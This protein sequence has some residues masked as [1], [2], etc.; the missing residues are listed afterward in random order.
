MPVRTPS[1]LSSLALSPHWLSARR[2]AAALLAAG[3]LVLAVAPAAQPPIVNS[4]PPQSTVLVA[5]QDLPAGRTIGTDDLR[6]AE[7]TSAQLPD[8]ALTPGMDVVGRVVTGSVRRGEVMTDRRLLGPGLSA[9]LDAGVVAS[10]V[11]LVDLEVSA[12]LRPGDRVDI[13][14]AVQDA[15]SATVVAAG[16]VVLAVP[17][18]ES[19]DSRPAEPIGLVVVAVDQDTAARLAAAAAS[20]RLTATLLP[21]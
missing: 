19:E 18:A 3:A 5:A 1:A 14:A 16:V 2:L 9:S 11:R 13:L 10:P 21:P 8:G 17:L 7:R 12:L 6:S 15:P 20:G 4:E